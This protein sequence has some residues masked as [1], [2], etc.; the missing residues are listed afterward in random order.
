M[1][2]SCAIRHLELVNIVSQPHCFG[3]ADLDNNGGISE[4]ELL[5][6]PVEQKR[7]LSCQENSR[8][9]N[10]K[11]S[12][13]NCQNRWLQVIPLPFHLTFAQ[14]KQI[15]C[16]HGSFLSSTFWAD[17]PTKMFIL[18]LVFCGRNQ[19]QS[20]VLRTGHDRHAVSLTDHRMFSALAPPPSLLSDISAMN[21]LLPVS[22]C[23]SGLPTSPRSGTCPLTTTAQA[24]AERLVW[25]HVMKTDVAITTSLTVNQ[26]RQTETN[27]QTVQQ[28][29]VK[30]LLLD[31]ELQFLVTL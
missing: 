24:W 14:L 11:N 23:L 26:K 6:E 13:H 31:V 9:Y 18:R 4:N 19:R 30:I 12:R 2:F 29:F 3:S 28:R 1:F 17:C 25:A 5:V 27:R 21:K 16:P 22:V 15:E 8:T 20:S 7:K 10:I